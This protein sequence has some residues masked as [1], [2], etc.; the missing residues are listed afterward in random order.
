LFAALQVPKAY[1][2][3]DDALASKATLAQEDIR[4]NR[5]INKIQRTILSE[6]NKIASIHLYVN[7]YTDE[8]L[9]D[10]ELQLS[11]PSTL[12]QQQRLEIHRTMFEIAGQAPEGIVSLPWIQKHIF[13]FSDSQIDKIRDEQKLDVEWQKELED[14]GAGDEDDVLGGGGGGGPSGGGGGLGGGGAGGGGD[15]FSGFDDLLGDESEADDG[16]DAGGDEADDEP[17]EEATNLDGDIIDELDMIGDEGDEHVDEFAPPIKPN[18]ATKMLKHNRRRR[19]TVNTGEKQ[20]V[21]KTHL[22]DFTDMLNNHESLEDPY[23]V[24]GLQPPDLHDVLEGALSSVAVDQARMTYK[25]K[26]MLTKIDK[27]FGIG[28]RNDNMLLESADSLED[29]DNA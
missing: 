13:R 2:G 28:Q 29:D 14:I 9:L 19:T 4:F 20:G 23:D 26:R 18:A 12:A 11:N 17:P 15:V 6:L 22:V 24:A 21:S 8:S 25:L 1:L 16:D 5:T 10:F 27:E 7:G 3:Y